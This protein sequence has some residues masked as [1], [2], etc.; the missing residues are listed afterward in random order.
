MRLEDV[1]V[2]FVEPLYEMNIGYIAR[3]MKNFGL[4]NLILIKPRCQLGGEAFRFATHAQEILVKARIANSLDELKNSFDLIA[5]T[6]GV[7]TKSLSQARRWITPETF[8]DRLANQ[9]GKVLIVLG[10]EDIG[11]TNE[12]LELCDIVVFIPANPQYPILNVSHA[13]AILFYET[14]KHAA[15]VLPS[16]RLPSREEVEVLLY[17]LRRLLLNLG[18]GEERA[19]RACLMMRR[20]VGGSHPTDSDVRMLLGVIRRAY[21][22]ICRKQGSPH[23]G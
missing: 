20:I 8:A 19:E 12:E 17:Y 23:V 9:E 13:A 10:R 11:L 18:E 3:C 15:R 1:S 2:A 7:V 21:E 14:Y 6:T 22:N 4:S 5:G 16:Q